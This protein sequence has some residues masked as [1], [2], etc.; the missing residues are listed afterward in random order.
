MGL[1]NP[2][3]INRTV[4]RQRATSAMRERGERENDNRWFSTPV[5]QRA[6]D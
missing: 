1:D 3:L 2:D 4:V 6:R 5:S